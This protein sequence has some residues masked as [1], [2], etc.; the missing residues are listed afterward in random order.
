MLAERTE[1]RN[2]F[3]SGSTSSASISPSV[4][5]DHTSFS[6]VEMK[7]E[8]VGQSVGL[9]KC[10][11]GIQFTQV[12]LGV[13]QPFFSLMV[14]ICLQHT[15]IGQGPKDMCSYRDTAGTQ[16]PLPRVLQI[17]Q[18]EP[19]A[20]Q[21]PPVISQDWHPVRS[22]AWPSHSVSRRKDTG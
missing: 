5:W 7:E 16:V 10:G 13:T 2:P 3:A 11:I 15:R 17:I 1:V 22:D 14:A 18:A 8:C 9:G 19:T 4:K 21:F 12:P 6:T 20:P